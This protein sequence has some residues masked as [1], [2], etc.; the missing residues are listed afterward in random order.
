MNLSAER[1]DYHPKRASTTQK[2]YRNDKNESTPKWRDMIDHRNSGRI[3]VGAQ[4]KSYTR[5][6]SPA[7]IKSSMLFDD[8]QK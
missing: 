5:L 1:Q 4:M 6:V 7:A 8:M 2:R 3:K